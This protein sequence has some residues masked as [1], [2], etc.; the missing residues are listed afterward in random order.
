MA[1][2]TSAAVA[3]TWREHG[4]AWLLEHG[5]HELGRAWPHGNLWLGRF[6]GSDASGGGCRYPTLDAA[7]QALAAEAE[8]RVLD[9]L[10]DDAHAALRQA[11]LLS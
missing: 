1:K 9:L 11:G 6:G 4:G 5:Q 2:T 8:T 10:S 7:R 3:M